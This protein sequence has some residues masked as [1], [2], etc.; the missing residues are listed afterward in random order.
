[1]GGGGGSGVTVGTPNRFPGAAMGS[2]VAV[3]STGAAVGGTGVG[4]S[5]SGVASPVVA[6]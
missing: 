1:M 5:G 4:G 3:G 2:G 6:V